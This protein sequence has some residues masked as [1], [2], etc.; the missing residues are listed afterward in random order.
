MIL[1]PSFP[2]LSRPLLPPFFRLILQKTEGARYSYPH[3]KALLSH[4]F[5]VSQRSISP[6]CFL[7]ALI[8]PF[9]FQVPTPRLLLSCSSPRNCARCPTS[10]DPSLLF[11][12]PRERTDLNPK[13]TSSAHSPLA[14]APTRPCPWRASSLRPAMFLTFPNGRDRR[15][16]ASFFFPFPSLHFVF[17][18]GVYY[19]HGGDLPQL[20]SRL[21]VLVRSST[22]WPPCDHNSSRTAP[23]LERT[24]AI[25]FA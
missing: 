15:L 16:P 24:G 22:L 6:F 4:A 13:E 7:L 19:R 17:F 10:F 2:S 21:Q 23:F 3:W 12:P 1:P 18:P 14:Q 20:P 9:F 5:L 11:P 25:C 8:T